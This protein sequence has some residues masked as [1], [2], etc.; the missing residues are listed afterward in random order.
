MR[1]VEDRISDCMNWV[2]PF[3]RLN[4]LLVR[5]SLQLN[6][7]TNTKRTKV[8]NIPSSNTNKVGPTMVIYEKRIIKESLFLIY[9][10]F[11][12]KEM[13]K[14]HENWVELHE[15]IYFFAIFFWIIGSKNEI[16]LF[17]IWIIKKDLSLYW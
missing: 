8:G 5:I 12:H 2:H 4:T 15:Y 10:R 13:I 16:H 14:F 9:L 11:F 6:A 17:F 1:R 3:Y 7:F